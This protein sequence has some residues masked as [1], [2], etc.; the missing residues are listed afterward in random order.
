MI[1][2]RHFTLLSILLTYIPTKFYVEIVFLITMY[3]NILWFN[4]RIFIYIRGVNIRV[5]RY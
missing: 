5:G 4:Q 1:P 2:Q 3:I